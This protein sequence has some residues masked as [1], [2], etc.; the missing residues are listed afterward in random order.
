MNHRK[1]FRLFPF[2]SDRAGMLTLFPPI[3][4][5]AFPFLHLL[6]FKGAYVKYHVAFP[7]EVKGFQMSTP[8]V[9]LHRPTC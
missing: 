5:Q 2:G 3:T 8:D 1:A 6:C 9:T 4:Q 7:A